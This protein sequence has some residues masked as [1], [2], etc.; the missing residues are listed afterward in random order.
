MKMATILLTEKDAAAMLRLKAKT[1]QARRVTGSP[2]K[3]VKL[4]RRTVR[5]RLEDLEQYIAESV[6]NSTSDQGGER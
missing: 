4:G 5:Y 3:F 2:P 6:R 1:L